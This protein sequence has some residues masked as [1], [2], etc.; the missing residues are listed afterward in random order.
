MIQATSQHTMIRE[1]SK[2]FVETEINP[3]VDEWERE[4]I[5]PR[6]KSSKS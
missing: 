1:T 2:K 4:E 6:T 3:Y 5:Y